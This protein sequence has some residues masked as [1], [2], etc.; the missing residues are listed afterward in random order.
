MKGLI[1]VI[2]Y[3]DNE[4]KAEP[5][6]INFDLPSITAEEYDVSIH[7]GKVF[8]FPDN[9]PTPDVNKQMYIWKHYTPENEEEKQKL[10]EMGKWGA[11]DTVSYYR[12]REIPIQQDN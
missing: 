10:I 12:T 8:S 4:N 6:R 2:I 7:T 9:F 5:Y 1:E 11:L 3:P